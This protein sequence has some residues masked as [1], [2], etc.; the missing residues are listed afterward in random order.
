ME[1]K[2]TKNEDWETVKTAKVTKRNIKSFQ[3]QAKEM[4]QHGIYTVHIVVWTTE[5]PLFQEFYDSDGV[6]KMF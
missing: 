2:D 5:D 6:D 1:K 3:K 4:I